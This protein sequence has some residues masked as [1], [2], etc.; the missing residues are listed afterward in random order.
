M[1]IVLLAA[2]LIELV[3]FFVLCGFPIDVGYPPNTPWYIQLIGLQWLALH[4]VGLFSL[5]WFERIFGCSQLNIVMGC[6][7]VDTVVLFAGGYLTT[8]LL[9]FAATYDFQHIRLRRNL[10]TRSVSAR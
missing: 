6:K 7:Q 8:V 3:N 2:L 9:A 4:L 1:A 5:S 10:A